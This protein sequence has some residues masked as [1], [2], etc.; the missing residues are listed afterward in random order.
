MSRCEASYTWTAEIPAGRSVVWR[1]TLVKVHLRKVTFGWLITQCYG[2]VTSREWFMREKPAQRMFDLLLQ[3]AE[4]FI[5]NL[6]LA[7]LPQIRTSVPVAPPRRAQAW[8]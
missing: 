7:L 5:E 4:L 8:H 2:P 1:P 6:G 3:Q